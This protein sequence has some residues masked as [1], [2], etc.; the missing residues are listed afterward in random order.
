MFAV[1][2]RPTRK[3]ALSL[4]KPHAGTTNGLRHGTQFGVPM[5]KE[6]VTVCVGMRWDAWRRSSACHVVAK[7]LKCSKI[8]FQ[9]VT[10]CH[11]EIVVKCT[12]VTL[13]VTH[14]TNSS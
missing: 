1:C 11:D 13:G 8:H 7:I 10:T 9:G 3:H 5:R 2:L 4:S 14:F 12:C 6:L